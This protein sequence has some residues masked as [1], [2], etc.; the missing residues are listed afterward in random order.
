MCVGGGGSVRGSSWR[1]VWGAEGQQCGWRRGGGREGRQRG[2]G[3]H[4]GSSGGRGGGRE[5]QGWGA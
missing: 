3:G 5:R 1:G 4:R 2:G